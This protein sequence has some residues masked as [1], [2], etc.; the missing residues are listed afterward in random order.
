M[1]I[2]YASEMKAPFGTVYMAA[3]IKGICKVGL[4]DKSEFYEWL[5][6][7]VDAVEAVHRDYYMLHELKVQLRRYFRSKLRKFDLKLDLR[8]TPFQRRVWHGISEIG[9]GKT[10][11]YKDLTRRIGPGQGYQAVGNAC[12]A[13]PIPI[14][15]PCHRVVGSNSSIGGFGAG[16]KIKEYLLQ[17]EGAILI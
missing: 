13:N 1:E 7:H 5:F 16:I 6:E 4:G 2:L 17:H 8:G 12:G 15:V 14:V 3:T 9:Y 11:T 10:L